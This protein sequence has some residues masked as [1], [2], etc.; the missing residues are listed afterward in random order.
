ARR[1]D[2]FLQ[3]PDVRAAKANLHAQNAQIGV[4]LANRL[5]QITPTGNAGSTA[6]S[7]SRLSS[8]GTLLWTV[9]G[10]AAQ[11]VFDAGAK[12][13]KQKAAEE[14]TAQAA[15]QYRSAVLT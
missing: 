12:Y 3:R 7:I 5:P 6:D 13:Y 11:T 4:A 9:A 2:L 1:A 15:A 8:R 10:D 14:A